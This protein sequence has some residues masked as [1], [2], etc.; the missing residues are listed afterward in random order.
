MIIRL[1]CICKNDANCISSPDKLSDFRMMP[2]NI[3]RLLI[4]QCWSS[5]RKNTIYKPPRK[6]KVPEPNNTRAS[7]VT[8]ARITFS[9]II[10]PYDEHK[11][12]R[13]TSEIFRGWRMGVAF[14]ANMTH[15][16][17]VYVHAMYIAC[18]LHTLG[19]A[20]SSN[21]INGK[22]FGGFQCSHMNPGGA[23]FMVCARYK[24][25][26]LANQSYLI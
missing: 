11:P 1:I 24:T 15:I 22:H 4:I 20:F 14:M 3:A 18:D 21:R 12:I 26:I 9:L 17:D 8:C 19:G 6:P 25:E 5:G 16:K 13:P 7:G 10:F 2:C 23:F